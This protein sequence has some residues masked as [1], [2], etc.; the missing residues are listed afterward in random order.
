MD[1][2]GLTVTIYYMKRFKLKQIATTLLVAILA[3]S[4]TIRVS[5]QTLAHR[6]SFSDAPGSSTFADSVSGADGTLSQGASANPN[7]AFLNGTQL[8]LDGTGGYG[9][10]PANLISTNL[11]VTIEFWATYSNNPVWTRTFAFGDQ[12][13]GGTENS[14]LDY[15]HF[16]GGNYQNL[17]YQ[18]NSGSPGLYVNNPAGLDG[19]ANVHVTVI[20]DPVNNK[21]SYYNGTKLSSS[22]LQGGAPAVFP[23]NTLSDSFGLIGRSLYDADATLAASISDFRIYSGTLSISNIVLND[24][25]GSDAIISGAGGPLSAIHL[26][27]PISSLVVGQVSQ[28]LLKGDFPNVNGVDLLAYGTNGG[29]TATFTSGNTGVLTVNASG[30]VTATGFGTTT[31]IA[32]YGSFKATNSL[33]VVAIPA[34]LAHRY[35]FT[36]DASDSIG[37]ANGTLNGNA[38][39]TGGKLV[40]DGGGSYLDIPGAAINI[41]TN[42]AITLEAWVTLDPANGTW[43]RLF[44]FG[45]GTGG[46]EIYCAPQVNGGDSSVH[47]S[48]NENFGGGSQ[49]IDQSQSWSGSTAHH[50]WIIDPNT[51]RLESYVNGVLEYSVQNATA[52]ISGIATNV[53]W[54]GKSPFADPYVIGS[55]DEFRIYS[56]ALTAQE[57]AASFA[58]GPNNTNHNP[59]T[60]LSIS[61]PSMTVPAFS[62]M[63]APTVLAN[64][65]NLTGLSLIPNA[66][67]A[68]VNGLTLTSSDTNVLTFTGNNMLRTLRPG[69]V[70]LS[71]TFL[72]KTASATITVENKGVLAHRYSFTTDASDSID[73]ANGTE[74]GSAI[75]SGGQLVLDGSGGTYLS[76]PSNL[77]NGY[78]AVTIDTWVTL[79]AGG[80]WAR[81]WFF[82]DNQNNEFY[83]APQTISGGTHRISSGVR[84]GRTADDA[85]GWSNQAI[86]I[87][88]V[89]GNGSLEL[90]SNAVP[91]RTYNDVIG[92]LSQVGG[93]IAWIGRSPYND[94]YMNCNVDEFRIYKG[95]LSAE[96]IAASEILGANQLLSTNV[97]MSVTR[98]GANA[99]LSWPVAAAGFSAQT[100]SNLTSGSWVTLTNAPALSGNSKWQVTLPASGAQ[101]FY[102]LWR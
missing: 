52:P 58:S 82:G 74:N 23:L 84:D 8:Q 60:L 36:T 67:A 48:I 28:Q 16:A 25:A 3:T 10:L 70:T 27:S 33:T 66:S 65:A 57:V 2:G 73:G 39:V 88:T 4:F 11:Q 1:Q 49:T 101:Q 32:Q 76:L 91:V 42:S 40:L 47:R 15:T 87:T 77:F 96:E 14:G 22:G 63:F 79:N 99:V 100:R 21:M 64:Y 61:V 86:H 93:S 7:S 62:G 94:P 97:T 26:V 50:V 46:S 5:S 18:T 30:L 89:Y 38:T 34:V 37:G 53:V 81:L 55:I 6:Y 35:S 78:D 9:V 69:T 72:G 41:Q 85:P 56:G 43:A 17:N 102:R 44:E 75:E 92:P 20:V 95:R 29:S 51:S 71:A 24:A 54:L 83:V 12:T 19:Q 31:V 45:N 59:G 68:T 80:T 13:G 98:S 90:Y